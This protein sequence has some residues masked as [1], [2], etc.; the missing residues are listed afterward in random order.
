ME[1]STI[2]PWRELAEAFSHKPSILSIEDDGSIV[3]NGYKKGYLHVVDEIIEVGKD[4]YQHPRTT[5][6]E[7]TEFLTKRPLKLKLIKEV[8]QPTEEQ[9]YKSQTKLDALMNK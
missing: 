5:M 3:H 8:K 9:I 7:N 1:G 4:I 6:E 2:T